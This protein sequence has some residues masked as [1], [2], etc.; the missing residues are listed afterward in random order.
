MDPQQQQ[1]QHPSDHHQAIPPATAVQDFRSYVIQHCQPTALDLVYGGPGRVPR[2]FLPLSALKAYFRDG[3][4][5]FRI[6][7][8]VTPWSTGPPPFALRRN[9]QH[10]Y[11]QVFAI[12]LLID[13]AE[14]IQ[15]F[16]DYDSLCDEALPFVTRP[17][18]FPVADPD[19][20]PLFFEAQMIFCA[21]VLRRDPFKEFHAR[22]I[23]PVVRC[24]PVGDISSCTYRIELHP[25]Y[26]ELHADTDSSTPSVINLHYSFLSSPQEL[27]FASN[28]IRYITRLLSRHVQ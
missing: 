3:D 7:R 23:L 2:S 15:D 26:N 10:H 28:R 9:I 5:V 16:I 20:Y 19:F 6:L 17:P 8:E 12:L 14:R 27:T 13:Q 18:E 25:D 4:R 11:P 22:T 1:R 24:E 21:P